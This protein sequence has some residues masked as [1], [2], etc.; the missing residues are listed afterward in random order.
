MD[1]REEGLFSRPHLKIVCLA[2]FIHHTEL[3]VLFLLVRSVQH[4]VIQIK[5]DFLLDSFLHYIQNVTD[6]AFTNRSRVISK[7]TNKKKLRR[8]YSNSIQYENQRPRKKK[9]DIHDSF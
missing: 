4:S 1:G 3:N 8:A 5:A 7:E 6:I 9:C 2:Y